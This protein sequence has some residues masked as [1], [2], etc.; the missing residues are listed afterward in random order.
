MQDLIRLKTTI[1]GIV[2]G[3]GMRPAI[4]RCATD[5]EITGFVNNTPEGV[6]I[7]AQGTEANTKR[8]LNLVKNSPPPQA[9]LDKITTKKVDIIHG[10]TKFEIFLSDHSGNKNTDISPDLATCPDCIKDI[11][12]K[13]NRRYLYPFTNCTNCGPRFTIIKDRP[14]DR[15]FTSMKD[16]PL[17]MDCKKEYDDP[18]NRRFHAQP[19]AC[20]ACGPQLS[21][22]GKYSNSP[23]I[24]LIKQIKK[25]K[26][27]A[28]KGLG[29][30]NIVCLPYGN[31]LKK[32]R[33]TKN[34]P[35]KSFAFMAKNIEVIE[36]YCHLSDVEINELK[37][38]RAPIVLLKKLKSPCKL[39]A[40]SPDNNY[41]GVMLPYTPL[42][43]LLMKH[44]EI[45]IM[46][47]ANLK[48]EPIAIND[49]EIQY[50]LEKNI[51]EAAL[52]H[53]RDIIHRADDSIVQFINGKR[54]II[55]RSRGFVPMPIEINCDRL[56]TSISLGANMK[57]TFAVRFNNKVYMSQHIGELI[58][59]RSYEFQKAEINDF[60]SL[61]DISPERIVSDAHPGHENYNSEN[62][63]VYH[64]YAHHLSVVLEHN[65]NPEDVL[66]IICDGTGYGADETIWGF[67]FLKTGNKIEE[68]KRVAHLTPFKLPGSEIALTE[69]DRINISLLSSINAPVK[70]L[71]E[72]RIKSIQMLLDKDLNSPMTSSLGR[73]FDGVSSILGITN[74]SSYEARAAILLQKEAE[75]NT[76]LND[77]PYPVKIIPTDPLTINYR[78]MLQSLLMD[79]DN[80]TP[81]PESAYKFHC[82]IVDSIMEVVGILR[83]E[84][85][86]LS[87]GC[88][89]N[90]LLLELLTGRL[91]NKNIRYY[92][93][94]SVPVNDAG[95]SFGQSIL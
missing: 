78:D 64:H 87:G 81:V 29:G 7:E 93:N 16:F 8:F 94:E 68:F 25:N 62:T 13:K 5:A 54:Q 40:V 66:G 72:D 85:V 42:H 3:V 59:H 44:F 67:E 18:L 39:E 83:P 21:L 31:A 84:V 41:H 37:S 43:H 92:T 4:Y 6:F 28:I 56:N 11:F 38:S 74:H 76:N 55:R 10:E 23:L 52:T 45:L 48:D 14:Y 80:H 33:K 27:A 30:F 75:K 19:N 60:Q 12:D 79:I 82:W 65:L 35:T 17:C 1:E 2:Q 47:S 15:P 46:T 71:S 49:R 22:I 63:L 91:N 95:I 86:A 32:L 51:I 61:L 50:L 9:K 77:I 70:N 53:N 88:F 73:L 89:Q 36:K 26:V 34:R 57:N 69:V 58:D 90:R 20:P 24:D